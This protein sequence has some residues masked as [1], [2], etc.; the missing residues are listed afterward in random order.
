M[1]YFL[2][3]QLVMVRQEL[4]SEELFSEYVRLELAYAQRRIPAVCAEDVVLVGIGD[5]NAGQWQ[6][7][8][9]GPAVDDYKEG[10]L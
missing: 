10:G 4:R 5:F 6:A 9:C 7:Y 8:K 1:V 2:A 3:L